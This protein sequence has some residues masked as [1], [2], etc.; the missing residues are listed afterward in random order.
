MVNCCEASAARGRVGELLAG[1]HAAKLKIK[2]RVRG[3][4]EGTR[5]ESSSDFFLEG[6]EKEAL[7][8]MIELADIFRR[9]Q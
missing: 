5:Y 4:L 3:L 8:G 9:L 2:S 7:I 6:D 1:W